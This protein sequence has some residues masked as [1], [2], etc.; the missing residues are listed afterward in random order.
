[1][2]GFRDNSAGGVSMFGARLRTLLERKKSS[3][4]GVFLLGFH[5]T[6]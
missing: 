2:Y 1:M 4:L 6:L 5:T 3:N